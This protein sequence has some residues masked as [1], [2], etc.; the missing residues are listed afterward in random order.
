MRR[1][2]LLLLVSL[3]LFLVGCGSGT[4]SQ[5][6]PTVTATPGATA[7]PTPTVAPTPP[8]PNVPAR[9]VHFT[10]SDHI[11][12]AGSLYGH[13]KTL[14]ICSHMLHTTREIWSESGIP[15]R[16]AVQGYEVLAYDF[17]GNGDS[18][19]ASDIWSLDVDLRAAVD[20]A[21]Q[22]GATK[23]VLMGASMGGTASLKVAAE[24]PVTAVISLS[25]PQ[26]FSVSVSDA[27]IKALGIPKLFMASETDQ[28]FV[29]DAKHMY[30]IASAPKE[31]YIYP[32]NNHGTDIF[33]GDNGDD[34]AQRI[35]HFL[36]QY[37]PA[38]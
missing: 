9:P 25:G 26:N 33:G 21:R 30:T 15:Q 29:T 10:T 31:I 1:T 11:R 4:T 24:I 37:A 14:V 2:R 32:G 8:I 36:A 13:G 34:P 17:R 22:Q 38:G 20:F 16:L 18:E 3:L 12:L 19:G 5:T 6:A 27:E 7:T 28:P 23:I 35:F